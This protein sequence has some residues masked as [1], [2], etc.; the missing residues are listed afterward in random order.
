M[1]LLSSVLGGIGLGVFAALFALGACGGDK[2]A[3]PAG[4]GGST[5]NVGGNSNVGGSTSANTSA[6]GSNSIGGT[7]TTGT[8]NPY[9]WG[10]YQD[11]EGWGTGVQVGT[12]VTAAVTNV[13]GA[14]Y[15]DG[16]CA[17]ITINFSGEA[18]QTVNFM[19]YWAAPYPSFTGRTL[20]A[21]I[22]IDDPNGLISDIELHAQSAPSYK[23]ANSATVSAT[24]SPSL[25]T[26][27]SSTTAVTISTPIAGNVDAG[28]TFDSTQVQG[29]GFNINGKANATGTA[30][31]YV[32]IVQVLATP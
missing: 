9:V 12:V 32:D 17:D 22:K 29:V 27:T 26:I 14:T 1:K 2:S 23:W 20:A 28:S 6:G 30:H 25:S 16:G 11:S 15:C 5:A 19:K 18:A 24:T 3:A 13:K 7:T 10:F 8:A 31:L 4:T 21:S